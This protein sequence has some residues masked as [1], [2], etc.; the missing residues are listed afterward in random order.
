[1][2]AENTSFGQTD[3]IRLSGEDAT[4]ALLERAVTDGKSLMSD[5]SMHDPPEL[6]CNH[7]RL[8]SP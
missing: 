6:P 2:N 8:G 5:A 3:I 4:I 7:L 1:M